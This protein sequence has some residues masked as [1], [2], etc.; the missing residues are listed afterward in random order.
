MRN[1]NFSSYCFNTISQIAKSLLLL[2]IFATSVMA[3]KAIQPLDP[4][5]YER[6]LC[7]K[8]Q[9]DLPVFAENGRLTDK[10]I[11]LL[12]PLGV[13]LDAG[14]YNKMIGLDASILD[15]MRHNAQIFWDNAAK[16][17]ATLRPGKM[18]D[19]NRYFTLLLHE[20]IDKERLIRLLQS[21]PLIEHVST[22]PKP[23]DPPTPGNYVGNQT[24]L[25]N[26][27]GINANQ[28][29]STYNNRGL[30]IKVVDIE[31]AY[32]PSHQ[33]LPNIPLV[34]GTYMS[35]PNDHNHGTAVLGE[36]VSK[37]NGWGTTGIASAGNAMFAGNFDQYGQYNIANAISRAVTASQ[38]GD[39]ILIEQHLEGPNS[40]PGGGQFGYVPV[41]YY[42]VFYDAVKIAVG[43][44]RIV[45]EAA[46]NGF[47]NLDETVNYKGNVNHYPF[48]PA[49]NSGA[50]MVGAGYA[51]TTGSVTARSRMDYSN[52]GAR[53]N[54]Q[55][56]GE[57]V[58]TTGYGDAYGAEGVNYWYTATFSGTSSAS[59]IVA[60]ACMLIQSMYKSQKNGAVLSPL[61]IRDL[62]VSTGKSQQSGPKP[63]SEKIGPL[64]NAFA[65]IQTF[66]VNNTCNAPTVSQ[67]SVTNITSS[68]ARLNCSVSGVQI[69][70]WAYR[71]VGA[72]TWTDLSST[73][74]NY[75]NI[76]GL[77][78]NKQ[79]EFLAAVRCN[80][81]TWSNWSSTKTFT[82]SGASTPPNDAV[83]NATLMNAGS[84]CS[85]TN[86]SNVGA[87]A[88]YNDAMC[89][90]T[91]PRDVWFRCAIP[92]T[93]KVT[94][95]TSAGSLSDA[96]MGVFWGSSCNNLTYIACEDD[97]S[98]G[99]GSSMPV[100][101]INGQAGTMLWVRVWGYNN[102]SGSFS[103]CAMNYSTANFGGGSNDEGPVY[104]I[105]PTQSHPY[106]ADQA[107]VYEETQ[108]TDR[109]M[110]SHSAQAFV[111][112]VFPNPTTE[113]A[114]LPYTLNEAGN[115]QII[116]CDLLGRMVQ[117]Q[118]FE[119]ASG[120]H[121]AEIDLSA[122][123]PGVYFVRFRCGDLAQ[124]QQ[125]QVIR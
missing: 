43:N 7:I 52:Y 49:S 57:K 90:T 61:Q 78:A 55:A 66:V 5:L 54:V 60:G 99:N 39:I 34:S 76:S 58:W 89:S 87:T 69:Y 119:Q 101:T 118:I 67:L 53:L 121:Q 12:A 16:T 110:V 65:A 50:I 1:S 46:G 42:K 62:L 29:Y 95:R 114:V 24:Y 98:N 30:G 74:V 120:E 28:V 85:Y 64:P 6:L 91:N 108:A 115:V 106:P 33:D 71:Q 26:D 86:S 123:N 48:S 21:S 10:G 17:D 56:F 14:I 111:G 13:A 88:T 94:F 77:T 23:V 112:K 113:Q 80:N 38:A 35:N 51:A 15:E 82:T 36:M 45:V 63:I 19:M 37:D 31:G 124:V 83:C 104:T 102:A 84:S 96:V 59:P 3:Q 93:G 22:M 125:I 41:E 105:D 44:N 103:I 100:M 107:Q 18:A 122:L 40:Y 20:G 68:S 47:Q 81:N 8:F 75:T 4:T 117:T 116:L 109:D 32:N 70:D 25:S 11:G 27:Y 9:D 79:Y 97:N 92:S 72:S 73:T 2:A